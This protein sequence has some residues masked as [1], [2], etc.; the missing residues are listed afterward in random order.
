MQQA[1]LEPAVQPP[2]PAIL[3]QSA[4]FAWEAEGRL[5]LRNVN[6][7]VAHGYWLLQPVIRKLT[8]PE[9]CL[10]CCVFPCGC[11]KGGD[12]ILKSR[13]CDFISFS[14]VKDRTVL[15][16]H[17]PCFTCSRDVPHALIYVQP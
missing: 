5:T 8:Q 6:L 3:L 4:S 17:M 1:E 12:V 10:R 15:S 13:Q 11:C 7:Q 9:V 2:H 14:V 16:P